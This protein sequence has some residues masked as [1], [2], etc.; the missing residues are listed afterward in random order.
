VPIQLGRE[1]TRKGAAYDATNG[2]TIGKT[3]GAASHGVD[4]A[5]GAD[6]DDPD[7]APSETRELE[8]DVDRI[9]AYYREAGRA[10]RSGDPAGWGSHLTMP[11]IRVLYFLGRQGHASVGEV[12]AE[13]GVTQPSATETL[14]K[15]VRAGL[16]V[17]T[18]DTSDRRI[19][20]NA[21]TAAGRETI[22]QP[23]EAR[24]AAL[25]SALRFATTRE[26]EA[27]AS[28]L[29]LL[30]AVL[31][32]S[33]ESVQFA[34]DGAKQSCAKTTP[35]SNPAREMREGKHVAIEEREKGIGE[36]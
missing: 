14:E 26:R 8:S 2:P 21:L 34:K 27:I 10:L 30:C 33:G 15:L 3:N 13:M 28:G 25:G 5:H 31:Q 32:R 11:Q 6:H 24:R 9:V 20:R 23:W 22:D 35:Q 29:E 12:A 1:A 18:A 7:A 4:L 36:R 19:V 16:V 17:R